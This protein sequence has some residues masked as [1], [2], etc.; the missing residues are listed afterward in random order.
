VKEEVGKRDSCWYVHGVLWSKIPV[1]GTNL[2]MICP[3]CILPLIRSRK[4]VDDF[5]L[6]ITTVYVHRTWR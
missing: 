4:L 6:L 3:K 2:H 5:R 1:I